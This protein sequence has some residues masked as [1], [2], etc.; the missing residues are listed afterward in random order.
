MKRNTSR[1]YEFS[2]ADLIAAAKE[3]LEALKAGKLGDLRTTT[4]R[5]PKPAPKL[6]ARQI[7]D[8][9]VRLGASQAVF[10]RLLNIPTRT[11]IAWE[12]GER[13]PSGAALKLL[14]IARRRPEVLA[15]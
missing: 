6:G 3:G 2:G 10:A 13:H 5:L 1:E 8:L 15:E 9:R 14:Q 4:L 11:A 7:R 12:R